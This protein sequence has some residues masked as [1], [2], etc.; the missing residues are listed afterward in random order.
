MCFCLGRGVFSF[1]RGCLVD[2]LGGRTVL[3]A[4]SR[5]GLGP[6]CLAPKRRFMMGK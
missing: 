1:G 4:L 3:I 5:V 6:V 2:G